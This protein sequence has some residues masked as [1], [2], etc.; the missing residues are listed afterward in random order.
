VFMTPRP[1]LGAVL[2][3]GTPLVGTAP[4]PEGLGRP[5]IAGGAAGL[6]IPLP[7]EGGAMGGGAAKGAGAGVGART[8]AGAGARTGAGAGAGNLG[9][10]CRG[11]GAGAWTGLGAGAKWCSS[12]FRGRERAGMA[13]G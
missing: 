9:A 8:G 7:K 11:A 10:A 5:P 6:G 3:P 12:V 4:G 13:L 2:S 1:L